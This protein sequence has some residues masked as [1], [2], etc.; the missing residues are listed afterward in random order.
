[1]AG[2]QAHTAHVSRVSRSRRW[3]RTVACILVLWVPLAVFPLVSQGGAVAGASVRGL[4]VLGA[5]LC[6]A[7]FLTGHLLAN[8]RWWA[9]LLVTLAPPVLFAAV[10]AALL[11]GALLVSVLGASG[12]PRSPAVV[13][14]A[15]ALVAGAPESG[16]N[17]WCLRARWHARAR[18]SRR[19]GSRRSGS[20]RA[21]PELRIVA[22]NTEYWHQYDETGCF[23]AYLR[24]LD[25][26]VYLLQEYIT[27]VGRGRFR[28]LDDDAA[29]RAAFPAYEVIIRGQLVTLSRLPVAAVPAGL[30][31]PAPDVLRVDIGPLPGGGI[32]ATYNVHIPVQIGRVSPVTR[33]F[34]QLVRERAGDRDRQLSGLGRD[35]AASG[36]PALVAGDFNASPAVGDVRRLGPLATDAIRSSGS[37]YPVSWNC[38]RR[39]FLRLWRLDWAF[40]AGGARVHRYDLVDPGG[41]SDHCLQSLLVTIPPAP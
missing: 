20:G 4:A 17:L 37:I 28:L 36:R 38:H 24:G 40:V 26:D 34:Y 12:P 35:L 31:G 5:C 2:D 13:L 39:R 10:P 9:W 23:Y 29:L 25:A 19:S 41:R 30:A 14:A 3:R 33:E 1:M 16:L 27:H 21:E 7:A 18:E 15:A 8:G 6:W 11:A 22:W 32:L